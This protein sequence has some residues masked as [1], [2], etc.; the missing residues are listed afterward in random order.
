MPQPV[1][2]LQAKLFPLIL[3]ESNGVRSQLLRL[4]KELPQQDIEPQIAQLLLYIRAGLT[5]LAAD[6]R[7]SATDI[8]L[9]AIETCSDEV[10]SCAGGW[11]KTL[12]CLLT[13][14]HWHAP[15]NTRP[16]TGQGNR[17]S[18]SSSSWTSYQAPTLGTSGSEGNLPAKTLRTLG[19]FLR[20]GLVPTPEP[21]ETPPSKWPFSLHN[22]ECHMVPKRSNAFA[23]LNL[24]GPP[25]DEESEMYVEREERQRIFH[26]RFQKTVESGL[27]A[28]KKEGG[29]IGRAV[30]AVDKALV[31]G[32]EGFE[33]D[34]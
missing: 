26:R 33:P 32:M 10:V 13:V 11:V 29:E 24:F 15:L 4:F 34:E 28:A 25:R 18:S 17:Q 30:A 19:A 12:K 5:H 23:R 31:D 1:S 22:V 27:Q 2:M 21:E 14:L 20:A 9:W 6:V 7:S 16:P 3:D 8:L